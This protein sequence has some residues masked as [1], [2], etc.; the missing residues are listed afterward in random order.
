MRKRSKHK[1]VKGQ[2]KLIKP[3]LVRSCKPS[4]EDDDHF[5]KNACKI[6]PVVLK[7]RPNKLNNIS[8]YG[9]RLVTCK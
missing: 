1:E 9:Y 5:A 6:C 2:N 3:T 8:F 4:R 7:N